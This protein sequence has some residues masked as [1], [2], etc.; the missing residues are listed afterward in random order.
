MTSKNDI[1]GDSIRTKG[2]LSKQGRDNWDKIFG[3][4]DDADLGLEGDTRDE[5]PH[6]ARPDGLSWEKHK[7]HEGSLGTDR[8]P[9]SG[10]DNIIKE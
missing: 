9:P 7:D 8:N 10:T 2:T 4:K 5:F 1:T 6:R 3:K